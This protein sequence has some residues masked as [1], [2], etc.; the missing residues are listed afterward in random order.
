MWKVIHT[1]IIKGKKMPT[2]LVLGLQHGDE[3]KGRV[4]DD[5]AV[6]WADV[7]VRFQGGYNAG[8]TIV[9]DD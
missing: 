2:K 6:D 3:G 7:V 8:H 5:I 9:V 1:F 4:V